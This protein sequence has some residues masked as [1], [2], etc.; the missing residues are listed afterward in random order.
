[1]HPAAQHRR[2]R[3]T[4][5]GLAAFVAASATW[6]GA[7]SAVAFD[8]G[9]HF[10]M[11][12]DALTTEGFGDKAIQIAQVNNWFVDFYENSEKIPQSGHTG[13]GRRLVGGG[14]F[15][16]EHWDQQ[17]VSAADRSHFDETDGGYSNTS[18]ITNEWDRLSRATRA[19]AIEAR[20]RNDPLQLLT[21]L[22]ISLHE[23]QDFYTHSNWVEPTGDPG[24]SGPG[25]GAKG[26]GTTPTW[27]DV[28]PAIRSAERIYTA[29]STGIVRDHGGWNADGNANLQTSMAKDWEGRPLYTEAY[30]A[31]YFASRQWVQGV[32]AAV[33]DEAFWARTIAFADVNGQLAT[34]QKGALN[35][36]MASGHWH[37]QGEPCSINWKLSCGARNGVGGNLLDLRSAIISFFDNGK[38]RYRTKWESLITRMNDPAASGPGLEFASSRPMQV[39]TRFVKTDITRFAEI[40]NLDIPGRA[41]MFMR[42]RV[43]GQ[44]YISGVINDRD[45][46][47]FHGANKPFSFLTAVANGATFDTPVQTI[48]IRIKRATSAWQAQMTTC[49]CASTTADGSSSTSACMTTS[50]A[51]TTTPTACRSTTQSRP[52][53]ASATSATSRSRS[54]VTAL[55]AGGDWA[56][57]RSGSTSNPWRSAEQSTNG[58]RRATAP[59]ASPPSCHSHHG[60]PP[61]RR[62]RSCGRWM[63][64][65]GVTM[66]TPTPT[67]GT[68][69]GTRSS[70]TPRALLRSAFVSAAGVSSVAE[71]AT[72]TARPSTGRFRPSRRSPRP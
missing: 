41:D 63:H 32:R 52:D 9:P 5:A 59:T 26:W 39:S 8:T 13:I 10:D 30:T 66:I 69:V 55:P 15:S 61:S 21:A 68:G 3:R 4:R 62:S 47:N 72:G 51:V 49:T 67:A 58:L 35:I 37:G 60:T 14:L 36:S 6:I 16:R 7:Q 1:M 70:P 43:G 42:L 71:W 29:G 48:R 50:N 57:R 65:C 45:T 20:D 2:R 19:L 46:F 44:N 22:G 33:N 56:A 54:R 34:D 11:T 17:V 12:R 40:D 18:A 28:P 27:F 53:C 64:P 38:S 23:V 31:A 24:R 25:W